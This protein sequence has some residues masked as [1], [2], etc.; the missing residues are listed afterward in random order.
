MVEAEGFIEITSVCV[1]C[2][3]LDDTLTQIKTFDKKLGQP[4]AGTL[5]MPC[6][7][8]L[9]PLEMDMSSQGDQTQI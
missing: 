3:V 2:L 1:L 6:I 5:Q 8:N 9:G 7:L 4:V